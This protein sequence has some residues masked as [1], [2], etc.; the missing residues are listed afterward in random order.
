[1]SV[2]QSGPSAWKV[3]GG[4]PVFANGAGAT[5]GRYH[6]EEGIRIPLG[7]VIKQTLVVSAILLLFSGCFYFPFPRSTYI[8][9]G[10]HAEAGVGVIAPGFVPQGSARLGMNPSN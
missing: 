8:Q 6:C 2:K 9:P 10:V 5:D 3:C 7:G 1:M 4:I